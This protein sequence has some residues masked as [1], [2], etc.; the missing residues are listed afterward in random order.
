[1]NRAFALAWNT[2]LGAWVVTHE[3]ARRRRRQGQARGRVYTGL[4]LTAGLALPCAAWGACTPAMPVAG[5]TVT[6]T[7]LPITSNSFSSSVNNITVNVAAGTQMTA[8]FLGG[9]TL[10]MTGT[11]GTLN[12]AGAIDPSVLG[13]QS[14]LSTGVGIGN[15]S[16]TATTVNVLATGT[17][18]GTGGL[19]GS[20]LP[21]LDGMALAM[22]SAATGVVQFN[23]A[24]LISSRALLG[25]SILGAD[26]PVIAVSGGGTVNAVNAGTIEG[27]VGFQPSSTGHHF[28]N[29]GTILG[30]LSMGAGSA[31]TFVAVTGGTVSSGGGLGAELSGPGGALSFAATG[32]VDGGL[33]GD[34]ALVLQN[35]VVGS[36]NGVAGFGSISTAQYINFSRLRINSGTWAI[37]GAR[38]FDT[39]VL[40]GGVLQFGS[41]ALLGRAL[42]ANGGA[43]QPWGGGLVLSP[44]D[45]IDL[46]AGGLSVQGN[47]DTTLGSEIA[48]VGGLKKLGTGTL[49]LSASNRYSG[50]TELAGGTLQVG[51]SQA[52][53]SGMLTV[54]S[55]SSLRSSVATSLDN[56]FHLRNGLS[57]T[58]N[59][60]LTL[61]GTLAGVGGLIK[62][63]AGDL[64]LT[65]FNMFT[66]GVE[67][68][69][70]RLSV[71][72]PAALG[73][74]ALRV[75][76][77]ASLE[78]M[79]PLYLTNSVDLMAGTLTHMGSSALTLP[80]TISGP[81]RL[82]QSGP[83]TLTLV[84]SNTYT[85]G[86]TL[87]NG[88]LV[89]GHASALGGGA[90]TASGGELDII[91]SMDLN[92]V[93]TIDGT[94]GVGRRGQT[95]NLTNTVGGVGTLNKLGTGT[96]TLSGANSHAGGTG[97]AGGVLE[98][99]HAS[100]LGTGSLRVTGDATLRTSAIGALL[101]P[102]T[103]TNGALTIDV[104]QPL[105]ASGDITGAG[106]LVKQGN[107]ALTLTG[108]N[109]YTGGTDIVAGTLRGASD[110]MQGNIQVSQLAALEFGQLID[111]TYQGRLSG[112]G[113][114]RKSGA[115]ALIADGDSRQFIGNT[116]V[117][118]GRLIVGG[119][120]S[121][122]DAVWGGNVVVGTGA[123]LGGHGTL[124][125][126][127]RV[128][129]GAF[130]SP[131]NSIGTLS[132]DGDLRL[133]DGAI[134]DFEF[135][136]P[137]GADPFTA[138]GQG[139][140]VAVSGDLT[141][142][143][144]TLDVT[145]GGG[146]GAGLYR[147]FS[148]GGALDIS[149]GG[150]QLGAAPV[151]GLSI[152]YLTGA[153][154]INLINT[155][156]RELRF[157]NANGL[158]SAT[159]LG[160]GS[161]TWSTTAPVWTDATGTLTSVMTPVPSMAV[162]G[163]EAGTV[164]IDSSSGQVSASG[165]QFASDGY[166]VAGDGLAL[167]LDDQGSQPEIR[168]GDGSADSAFFTA[169]IRN[170]LSGAA[171][172]RKTGLGTLV[173]SGGNTYTGE[174]RIAG[175]AIAISSDASLG[176]SS[177]AL[178]LDGGVLRIDGR[179]VGAL[180]RDLHLDT[181]GGGFDISDAAHTFVVDQA[182]SGSGR[183]LKLGEGTLELRGAN[184]Y[185]GG[186][187]LRQGALLGTTRSIS[188]AVINE[189]RLIFDQDDGGVFAGG[190]TGSGAVVKRGEGA[191]SFTG[192]NSYTG[193]TVIERGQLTGDSRSLQGDIVN[194]GTLM[195]VEQGDG[196]Y[197]G[198][199]S[200]T[201]TLI[202]R[203][204]GT[205]RLQGA[206][207]HSG[208]TRVEEGTLVGDTMTL[209][210]EIFNAS[211]LGIDQAFDGRFTGAIT[212]RG[213]LFK[214][215]AG[216]V[217]LE[218]R[219]TYT[220]G[221]HVQDG[222]LRG[223]TAS[224]Q[225]DIA[226]DGRLVFD[227]A[228]SGTYAGVI[229]GGG[230]V[231]LEGAGRLTL[232]GRNTYSGGTTVASGVL[233]GTTSSLQ[234][235]IVNQASVV[236]DQEDDGDYAGRMS[237]SGSLIK[238]GN[239]RV[240]LTGDNSYTG[241][242]LIEAGSLR[243]A[244][245]SLRGDIV[246][247]AQLIIEENDVGSL[248]GALAGT[249]EL[250]KTGRGTLTVQHAQ[251]FAGQTDVRAGT[252]V[253]GAP[254]QTGAGIAGTVV[255]R[256][257]ATIGGSG[258]IGA[259]DLYGTLAPGHSI[260]TL[261]VAGNVTLHASSTF[262]VEVDS[263]GAHDRLAVGG[264]T[265][266][267]GGT[268]LALAS[269]T[270]WNPRS[271]YS[272]LTSAGGLTGQFDSV[273]SSL[274]FLDPTLE[275]G[276]NAITLSLARNEQSFSS[277]AFT[278]NQAST[279]DAL[280]SLGEGP[281]YER[282]LPLD[283]DAARQAFDAYSGEIRASAQATAVSDASRVRQAVLGQMNGIRLLSSG[284]GEDS[285]HAWAAAWG[286]RGRANGD[287]N[288]AQLRQ[289][290]SGWVVGSGLALAERA[291]V[292]FVLG[293]ARSSLEVRDR[294]S[295]ARMDTTYAGLYG[296]YALDQWAFRAGVLF[297]RVNNSIK[298]DTGAVGGEARLHARDDA[299]IRQGFLE[300]AR[301]I[302][303]GDTLLS[304]YLS[305]TGTEF[306][307]D[308]F[309]EQGAAGALVG[310]DQSRRLDVGAVGLRTTWRIGPGF[311]TA[312]VA[313]AGYQRVSGNGRSRVT[314]QFAEGGEDFSVT[315]VPLARDGGFAEIGLRS[316]LSD[317][318][319]L[320]IDYQGRSGSGYRDHGAQLSVTTRF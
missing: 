245:A 315:G 26:T 157:W 61:R 90:L 80:G 5:A 249:G 225:G 111:G 226:N 320:K 73:V 186:T 161:G 301:G 191:V 108:R 203:G 89:L 270:Q 131:G 13:L 177:A 71:G 201:G 204:D 42:T 101:N 153:R 19:L 30:S 255:V 92:T 288:A 211:S 272:I 268:V 127:V 76:G 21:T 88:S 289:H 213:G 47:F 59:Q 221:T 239:G 163:G 122:S 285:R 234:G 36:G 155:A 113:L 278:A 57:L 214:Q 65:G 138:F 86:T 209:Q 109:A 112:G 241:G 96:L 81:G 277:V 308:A 70:G 311:G 176:D 117:A 261:D 34:N 292:G 130:L 230:S 167:V 286:H 145:D 284:T 149:N 257:G 296:A 295:D 210:G 41:P 115:G 144:V 8:G 269:G 48:G 9:T 135:G 25:L 174:T 164:T 280:D 299:D 258:R 283:A 242:T 72:S 184:S 252:L 158:A 37:D 263:A 319:D 74:G 82:A 222:T 105:V 27:R 46:Q 240:V 223:D 93:I 192:T 87:T 128:A 62:Q 304:P 246:A 136:A 66:G 212:G 265:T 4:V 238:T 31:N 271:R 17:V 102:I 195:F 231:L 310:D 262:Q 119:Q 293:Q 199:L 317:R 77:D 187:E 142:G 103:L 28:I 53:G 173:L 50:G 309:V 20:S 198:E 52:L 94:L 236:I 54:T 118:Q 260:G 60:A 247:N 67:L 139:D 55:A 23:N 302:Q 169:T 69:A 123:A 279:A 244:A 11:N 15:A 100:A 281:V 12:V 216:T 232:A 85:G 79:T 132:V 18:Y 99:G 146:F 224:L 14:I 318:T 29:S 313:D 298:R 259:L 251:A 183:L 129:S 200:G 137:N 166:V 104:T 134:L 171:G 266:I 156:G 189:G 49:T 106:R 178:W 172:L 162:F 3:L 306:R 150:I 24:G 267:L 243:G 181:H 168:V 180:A 170:A 165:L 282:I 39:T 194:D 256:D 179:G 56:T 196:R 193:G 307:Q 84:G 78:A 35:S 208:G 182:L 147:I 22:T 143:R 188:G 233:Q 276:A 116:Q 154:Q 95:L 235:D 140:S 264:R 273:R 98:L 229:S 237:G 63:G 217:T 287:G 291:D 274:S 151:Q 120:A 6:C 2:T 32:L 51:H 160:G 97:L 300:L 294:G 219:Q 253:V 68:Q 7:G 91:G 228:G 218:G 303:M 175:G 220:G 202:K 114:V 248:L 305:Y 44:V 148:Y 227:Q 110:S 83:G 197:T 38:A 254:G 16:S 297:G 206:S 40:N 33:A 314:Q 185:S 107:D 64:T 121:R 10:A 152:Q 45:G 207:R 159:Q 133:D 125:G 43:L 205:L 1:M 316:R 312:L 215:G 190:I 58:G 250:L 141:L 126:D 290:G 275:Y 75:R 124:A